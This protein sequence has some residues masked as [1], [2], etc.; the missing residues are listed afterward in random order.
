VS[1][2]HKT[3]N[4]KVTA[5]D[6]A[7][8]EE[9]NYHRQIL[10]KVLEILPNDQNNINLVEK[11]LHSLSI[12][13]QKQIYELAE[14]VYE[15]MLEVKDLRVHAIETLGVWL[16]IP[17]FKNIPYYV[18]ANDINV[19]VQF[20]ALL[21][22]TSYY[23]GSKSPLVLEKLYQI[24]IN[25]HYAIPIRKVALSGILNV[26]NYRYERHNTLASNL[27]NITSPQTFH[28]QI[29]WD[30]ITKI[31]KKYVSGSLKIHPISTKF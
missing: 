9:V 28:E 23:T 19:D 15:V 17:W 11:C 16:H 30:L 25:E 7:S 12:I 5:M 8:R 29:N 14:E 21:S 10:G 2:H 3:N 13:N 31:M 4:K 27:M 1:K 22:W 6:Q 20:T 24:L 18:F 26:S